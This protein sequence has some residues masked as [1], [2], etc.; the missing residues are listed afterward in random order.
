MIDRA[1]VLRGQR[2]DFAQEEQ[3]RRN[4]ERASI[5]A[6]VAF[7]NGEYSEAMRLLEPYRDGDGLSRSSAM[8]LRMAKRRME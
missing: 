8:L 3:R 7:H 6:S 1:R 5:Q 4:R 2:M